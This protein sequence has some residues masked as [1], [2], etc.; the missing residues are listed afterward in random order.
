VPGRRLAPLVALALLS[1][2]ASTLDL[3]RATTLPRGTTRY[4]AGL[5][6]SAITIGTP[7]G[8]VLPFLQVETSLHHGL[9][10]RVEVG[11]RAW[12]LG[13]A[14]YFSTFGLA[15][16]GKLQLRRSTGRR[17]PALATGLSVAY[18]RPALGGTPWNIVG[19]TA[20]LLVGFDVGRSQLVFGPR[21]SAYVGGSYG[22]ATLVTAGFGAGVGVAIGTSDTFEV[23]PELTVTWN[24]LG[25][26]GTVERPGRPGTAAVELGMGVAWG[27]TRR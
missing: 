15:L 24:T 19:I 20:P 26:N 25:L 14:G 27:P 11:A 13:Y 3:G 12:G 22:Q 2:C 17:D 10:D 5:E 1:G 4:G 16:D 7:A 23:T 21:A 18:Y 8:A 6:A 9:T